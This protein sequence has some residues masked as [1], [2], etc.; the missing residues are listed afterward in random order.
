MKDLQHLIALSLVPKIG[1][2][3]AKELIEFFGTAEEVFKQKTSSLKKLHGFGEKIADEFK[4]DDFLKMAEDE[5]E[6][7]LKNDIKFFTYKDSNYPYRL[8]ECYDCPIVLYYRGEVDFNAEKTIS[9]V[10]TRKASPAGLEITKKIVA[11]LS[12]KGYKFT[13]ISGFAL[14]I[15][16]EAHLTAVRNKNETIAVLAHGLDT[17][18]PP[19]NTKYVKEIMEH[20]AFISEYRH[21][22]QFQR[23]NFVARNRIIAGLSDC[24]IITESGKRGGALIT[25]DF[26]NSYSREV[27]AVPGRYYDTNFAGCNTAIKHNKANLITSADD[28]IKQLNWDSKTKTKNLFQELPLLTDDEKIIIDILRIDRFSFN[29]LLRKTNI[30]Y[31][32]LTNTLV[33]LELNN[34]IN[35]LPGNFYELRN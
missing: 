11:D 8:K 13:V 34:Y 27:C 14:G 17:I 9:I 22:D 18:Y 5:I 20:G 32:K 19:Q 25:V 23:N 29:E 2:Q 33:G 21:I 10:G 35:F 12:D 31:N 24:T 7:I 30:P 1:G 6:F 16:I 26:A 28:I 3:R 15:D 4:K